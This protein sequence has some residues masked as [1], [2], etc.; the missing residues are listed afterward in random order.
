MRP[1]FFLTDFGLAD[2]FVGIMKG[3]VLQH[4]PHARLVDLCHAVPPFDVA[5]GAMMLEDAWPHLPTSAVVVAVIDPGVGTSRR[6]IAASVGDRFVIG[7]DNGLLGNL[8]GGEAGAVVRAIRPSALVRPDR[9][10]T[11][12]GRDVFAPAAGFLSAGGAFADLGPVVDDPK[13]LDVQLPWLD[14][15]QVLH[16]SVVAL[17]RFGNATLNLHRRH[18]APVVPWLIEESPLCMV[19]DCEI[20]GL[21]RTYADVPGG[22]PLVYWNSAD[23]L[24]LAVNGGSAAKLFALGPGDEVLLTRAGRTPSS[25]AVRKL[26]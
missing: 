18:V 9:S 1:V 15:D 17:D 24:E 6:P 2:P 8:L 5:A 21:A 23:R 11:F 16:L 14:D 12:H 22:S 10:A 3:V 13:P 25:M 4:A 7:P 19:G 26:P 20:R